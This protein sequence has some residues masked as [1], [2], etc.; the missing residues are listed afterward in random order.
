VCGFDFIR[1]QESNSFEKI[2][3][4]VMETKMIFYDHEN[5]QWLDSQNE[6]FKVSMTPEGDPKELEREFYDFE[7][8]YHWYRGSDNK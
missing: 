4:T 7:D 1:V 2:E 3:K 6:A 5:E 8:W